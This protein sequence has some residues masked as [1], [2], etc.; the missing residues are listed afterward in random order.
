MAD[1][2]VKINS[3]MLVNNQKKNITELNFIWLVRNKLS[4]IAKN[5]DEFSL[6]AFLAVYLIS[7]TLLAAFLPL[8]TERDSIEQ[9]VWSQSWQWGYYKHPPLPSAL[10]HVLNSLFG[11]PSI[12]LTA[13]AAQGCNVVALI[14]VWQLAK[15]ILPRKLAITAVLITSLIAYHNFR[16][17]TFNHNTVSLPF[18]AAAL[19]YFYCALRYPKRTSNWLWLGLACGLAMLTKYSAA[20][21]MTSFFVYIAWQR[22]WT[23]TRVIRG[24]LVSSVVF[25][26]VFSPHV[27]WLAENNWLPFTYLH[28]ELAAS[29][30]RV[31]ILAGFLANQII[32]LSFTLPLLLGVWY[33]NKKGTIKVATIH[34]SE[35]SGA[36]YDLCFLLTVL[37]TPL[38]LAMMPPLLTGSFLNS[39][40]VSAFFLPAGILATKCFFHRLDE[41]QLLKNANRLAWIT[42]TAIIVFFF[43]GSV[44]YPIAVGGAARSNFPSQALADKVTEIWHEHQKEPLAIVISDT[45][46]GGNVLL[47]VRPEPT[48]FIDNNLEESPWVNAHDV[49]ACGAFIITIK[50][51]TLPNAYSILFSQA[52]AKGEFS[53][54]WGHGPRG[55]DVQYAWAIKPPIPGEANCRFTLLPNYSGGK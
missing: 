17:L 7:W 10:L 44:I 23:N 53:L 14:Y 32:R 25:M 52:S 46:T 42:H 50:S 22:L 20:L 16:A 38:I 51:E 9:V 31:G 43:L 3:E 35:L 49:A 24:L 55:K 26:L 5:K 40:W 15:Q 28:D 47:H 27:V 30:N 18:T 4:F 29:G 11:G 41:A 21:V 12:G 8:S 1:I 54:A 36:N 48:L 45:W 33:L 39:N 6:F 2:W 37:L 19:Y 13:F 34:S